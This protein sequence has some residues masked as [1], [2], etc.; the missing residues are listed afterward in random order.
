MNA[1]AVPSLAMESCS[2][3]ARATFLPLNH[4]AIDLV[5]ATPAISLPRPNSMQ[6]T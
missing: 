4:F 3:I 6:P 2:P 1:A 5:T